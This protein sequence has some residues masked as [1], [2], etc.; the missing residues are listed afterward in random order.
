MSVAYGGRECVLGEIWP[1]CFG[2][3][4]GPPWVGNDVR[5]REQGELKEGRGGRRYLLWNFWVPTPFCFWSTIVQYLPP[6]FCLCLLLLM[7]SRPQCSHLYLE[8]CLSQPFSTYFVPLRLLTNFHF[9]SSVVIAEDTL[10][11]C[12]TGAFFF[13]QA[14]PTE[15][16]SF[17]LCWANFWVACHHQFYSWGNDGQPHVYFDCPSQTP[18]MT[19]TANS[20]PAEILLA[21][22]E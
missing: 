17:H 15:T 4:G 14:L 10:L 18:G 22:P 6:P 11:L 9:L 2:N 1:C 7:S 16:S 21:L 5:A 3:A 12:G 13:S 20:D 19:R 8:N